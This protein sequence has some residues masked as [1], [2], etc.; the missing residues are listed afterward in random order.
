MIGNSLVLD[1]ENQV[2]D[3]CEQSSVGF[4]LD[5]ANRVGLV[6]TV[7][8]LSLMLY[9]NAKRDVYRYKHSFA[10]RINVDGGLQSFVHHGNA[11]HQIC[12]SSG[13]LK[14]FVLLRK[15]DRKMGCCVSR[16]REVPY[17]VEHLGSHRFPRPHNPA[18]GLTTHYLRESATAQQYLSQPAQPLFKVN[19]RC[20][21][22]Q[23]TD[24]ARPKC[25][26]SYPTGV[27][28]CLSNFSDLIRRSLNTVE[29]AGPD[30]CQ[31]INAN[32]QRHRRSSPALAFKGL[33][34]TGREIGE[35]QAGYS[36]LRRSID[37][38]FNLQEILEEC[39]R[40]TQPTIVVFLDVETVSDRGPSSTMAVSMEQR[41]YDT[42]RGI[43][44]HCVIP[45]VEDKYT[46]MI[47][48]RYPF[49]K[50]VAAMS[51]AIVE[52]SDKCNETLRRF[53]ALAMFPPAFTMDCTIT[54]SLN[55]TLA[56]V[57]KEVADDAPSF[58][59]FVLLIFTLLLE[60]PLDVHFEGLTYPFTTNAVGCTNY[61]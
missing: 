41:P 19:L 58:F 42:T 6:R 47:R 50:R 31:K 12:L 14:N 16:G 13:F 57:R 51:V 39:H 22:C 5:G 23:H 4:I 25:G 28:C 20:T 17:Y 36:P 10:N 21:G 35:N 59:F 30:R 49:S 1:D 55:S 44:G 8:F 3:N 26:R 38:T 52:K 29:T 27:Y 40:F 15:A 18:R 46:G 43:V 32:R 24:E 45:A 9:I 7:N 37:Q 34:S 60:L 53:L 33:R 56:V 61:S 2:N 54:K 48:R 11:Y